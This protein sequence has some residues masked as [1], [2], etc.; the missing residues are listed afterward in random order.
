MRVMPK[1]IAGLIVSL[2]LAVPAFGVETFADEAKAQKTG[3]AAR[4]AQP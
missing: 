3:R 1:L 4:K 2:A